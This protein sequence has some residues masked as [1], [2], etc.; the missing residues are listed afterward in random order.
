MVLRSVDVLDAPSI[1]FGCFS[2]PY[3]G[4]RAFRGYYLY[5]E[6]TLKPTDRLLLALMRLA[7]KPVGPAELLASSAC[8]PSTLPRVLARLTSN[9]H[10]VAVQTPSGKAYS[11]PCMTPDSGCTLTAHLA[12]IHP[13][14]MHQLLKVRAT[15]KRRYCANNNRI[16][17]DRLVFQAVEM[18]AF[19]AMTEELGR[20]GLDR[21]DAQWLSIAEISVATGLAEEIVAHAVIKA[22]DD[23]WIGSRTQ[24]SSL[25]VH[26]VYAD[27]A[28]AGGP[29]PRYKPTEEQMRGD[30]AVKAV[31]AEMML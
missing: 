16:S 30:A 28:V 15:L 23:G 20:D 31:M 7:D 5:M 14:K 17:P 21:D 26:R 22:E 11:L 13:S 19:P 27:W 9:G 10:I 4:S 18:F 25:G 2:S 3:L 6:T 24:E 12:D 8:S 1:V 29:G